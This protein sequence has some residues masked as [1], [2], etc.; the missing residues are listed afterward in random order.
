MDAPTFVAAVAMGTL[1]KTVV[2]K[3]AKK[4]QLREGRPLGFKLSRVN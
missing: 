2:Q 3:I 4:L 1:T